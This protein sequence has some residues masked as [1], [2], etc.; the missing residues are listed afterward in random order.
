Q[1][2]DQRQPCRFQDQGAADRTRWHCFSWLARRLCKAHYRR[3]RE[4]GQG[5]QSSQHQAGVRPIRC[6]YSITSR[7]AK[8]PVLTPRADVVLVYVSYALADLTRTGMSVP[9]KCLTTAFSQRL[10]AA[11]DA[12][13]MRRTT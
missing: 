8:C 12:E 1:R 2:R 13:L 9:A 7:S 3:D 5:D 6:R 11:A 10:S 4:V